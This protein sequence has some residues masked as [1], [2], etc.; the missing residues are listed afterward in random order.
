MRLTSGTDIIEE[1]H[2]VRARLY[3]ESILAA[4]YGDGS[5]AYFRGALYELSR[6]GMWNRVL[7]VFVA[8]ALQNM[9]GAAG[10]LTQ[11]NAHDHEVY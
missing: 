4:K 1:V 10:E 11:M 7:L 6:K 8:F 2:Q 9:S 5:W 3:D